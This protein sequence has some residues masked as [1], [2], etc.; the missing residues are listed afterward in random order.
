MKLIFIVTFLF[1]HAILFSNNNEYIRWRNGLYS[2]DQEKVKEE[3][4]SIYKLNF[5]EVSHK[6]YFLPYDNENKFFVHEMIP[7]NPSGIILFFHGYLSHS[8][9][10]K[11]FYEKFLKLGYHIVA[12]DLPGHGLSDG[13]RTAIDDFST[14]ARVVYTTYVNITNIRL[15]VYLIGHST[16]CS[17]ILE[18]IYNYNA[19]P[20]AVV[21]VAPLVRIILWELASFGYNLFGNSVRELPRLRRESSQDIDYI[22]F[23]YEKDPLRHKKVDVSWFKAVFVWQERLVNYP[24]IDKIPCLILQ[25]KEDTVVEWRYNIDFLKNKLINYKIKIINRGKHDLLTEVNHIKES[26]FSEIEDFLKQ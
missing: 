15:P 3:Y 25:G 21:F 1:F 12:V 7:E 18:F 11:D 6:F 10:F 20:T 2:N 14:Y 23:I 5:S 9:L 26:V 8:G 22:N 4:L 16:G 19:S 24:E 17:A 13:R